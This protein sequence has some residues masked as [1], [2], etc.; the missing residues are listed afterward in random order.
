[1][2]AGMGSR[3]GGLKQL[4]GI[5]PGGE[6]LLE[7]S[8]YD[9]LRAGFGR[10]V[11][12]IRKEIEITFREVI[13]S[14][15]ADQ[16]PYTLAY[17][18]LDSLPKG[19]VPPLGR[20]KPWGTGHAV[21]VARE[22]IGKTPF[23]VINADDY[24]GPGAFAQL[25]VHL[26]ER[27]GTRRYALAAYRLENTL[28]A[29]GTVSRGVCSLKADGTLAGV[30]EVTAIGPDEAGVIRAGDRV[31]S[32]REQVSMNLWGF[33]PG[34]FELLERDFQTFLGAHG[35]ESKSEFY[36][37][38]CVSTALASGEAVADV[39]AVEDAWHGV[40]HR[41]DRPAVVAALQARVEAG[42][43]PARLWV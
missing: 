17:Q 1:M 11:F 36:L 26:R 35:Q 5:G 24:Y 42:D 10:V 15:F 16:V 32:G 34:F 43:Y 20:T 30:E 7:Y 12:V 14:R 27:A 38:A 8:I 25:A 3:Y 39:L 2:A 9:A 28:S 18:E 21:L 13:L 33:A 29:Y 23:A 41:E 4:E 37:P 31:F 19:F 22:V 40:T 6:T